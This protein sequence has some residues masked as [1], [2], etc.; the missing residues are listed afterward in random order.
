MLDSVLEVEL[1]GRVYSSL[2]PESLFSEGSPS[3]PKTILL[4]LKS[5]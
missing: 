5:G 1:F 2:L 4:I 3:Y